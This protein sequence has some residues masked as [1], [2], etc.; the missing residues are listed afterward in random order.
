MI[1]SI[2]NVD[3]VGVR[4]YSNADWAGKLQVSITFSANTFHRRCECDDSVGHTLEYL[5]WQRVLHHMD[6]PADLDQNHCY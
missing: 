4:V 1:S 5:Q 3:L 2:S 6:D